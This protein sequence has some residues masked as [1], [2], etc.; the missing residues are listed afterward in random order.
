VPPFGPPRHPAFPSGHS[1]LGHFIALLLL[2]IEGLR[3]HYGTGMKHDGSAPGGKPQW[4]DYKA[5]NGIDGLLF[6]LAARLARN[7]ERVGLHYPSDSAAGRQLA[8]GIWNAIVNDKSIR[9]PT[10]H[11]VLARA[12]AEWP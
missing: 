1:F 2:E 9:V 10:L 8:G 5:G 7:R 4:N 3:R 11:R 6:W 12:Q